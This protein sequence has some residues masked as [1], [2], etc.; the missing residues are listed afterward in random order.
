MKASLLQWRFVNGGLNLF[1]HHL[2]E[3][4]PKIFVMEGG[5]GRG[6]KGSSPLKPSKFS[7]YQNPA[8]SAALNA[9]SLRPANSTYL[10]IFCVSTASAFA[11]LSIISRYERSIEMIDFHEV[12]ILFFE[13]ERLG[14]RWG[15]NE[16][17][18]FFFWVGFSRRF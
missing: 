3:R 4:N 2:N 17:L 10:C 9:N 11:L 5:G 1:L 18:V 14:F 15:W 16:Y 8:F 12:L 6:E 13:W 7:V